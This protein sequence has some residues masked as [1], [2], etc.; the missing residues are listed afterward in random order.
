[1]TKFDIIVVGAGPAGSMAA[2]HAAEGKRKVCLLERKT[3][4]GVPVRCGEG[5]GRHGLLNYL[6]PQPGWIRNTIHKSAMVSPSG[7]RIELSGVTEDF[8]LDREKMDGDLVKMAQKAGAE[9]FCGTSVI[10]IEKKGYEYHVKC[11]Q[12]TFIA[13]CVILADGVESRLARFLGW[14]TSLQLSDVETCAFARVVSPLIEKDACIFY[15][16]SR[17]AP[18][19]Y[20]WIFP[21]GAGEANVGLGISG[22]HSDAGKAREYLQKFIDM[23]LPGARVNDVHCGGVPVTKYIKPLVKDGVMLVGDAA[24]QVN[25]LSGAGIAYSLYAGKTAGQVASQ[26]FSGDSLNLKHLKNYEK[27]WAKSFGKQQRRSYALKQFV[28]KYADDTFLNRVAQSLSKE[29]PKNMNYLKVFMRTFSGH[30]LLLL[31]AIKLFK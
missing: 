1:M 9:Y 18:G 29:D 28:A 8:V 30:P 20:A 4:A 5:I 13:P 14:N 23:E 10:S 12:T 22:N 16:G 17:V 7:I 19:G 6:E 3:D 15:T 25:C 24:R 21:R 27:S 2:L 31:K 11:P 26:A